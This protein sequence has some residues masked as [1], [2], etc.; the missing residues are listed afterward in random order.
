MPQQENIPQQNDTPLHV[1]QADL[2]IRPTDT[3]PPP[4]SVDSTQLAKSTVQSLAQAQAHE[5]DAG[6][7]AKHTDLRIVPTEE[8]SPSLWERA[9]DFVSMPSDQYNKKYAAQDERVSQ[10]VQNIADHFIPLNKEVREFAQNTEAGKQAE[11][12]AG[13]QLAH[14]EN[15][16]SAGGIDSPES[17]FRGAL[18]EIIHV[19]PQKVIDSGIAGGKLDSSIVKDYRAK[20]RNGEE[21]Q[22]ATIT[23][24]KNGNV[25]TFD[26]RHRSAAYFQEKKPT[27]PVKVIR[28]P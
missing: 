19:A 10:V 16:V 21:I 9:K 13:E 5:K 20:I 18:P 3:I 11:Q 4:S 2:R 22:P 1:A 8:S 15:L 6:L 7:A 24:D 26:G 12:F 25:T 17:G 14:P 27:M 28:K 23:F